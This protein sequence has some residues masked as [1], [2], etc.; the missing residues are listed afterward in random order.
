MKQILYAHNETLVKFLTKKNV[1]S[2]KH[3]FCFKTSNLNETLNV[4]VLRDCCLICFSS[5]VC[6]EENVMNILFV[7]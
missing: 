6:I 4:T 7:F 2:Y 1:L 3:N 5:C